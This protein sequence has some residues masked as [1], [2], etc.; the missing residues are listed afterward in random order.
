LMA[1]DDGMTGP[2]PKFE[3]DKIMETEYKPCI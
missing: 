2:G 1:D 3:N